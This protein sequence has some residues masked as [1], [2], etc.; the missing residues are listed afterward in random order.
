MVNIT[1]IG[2]FIKPT[3]ERLSKTPVVLY[4]IH[5]FFRI[6]GTHG[7]VAVL[8]LCPVFIDYS[9]SSVLSQISPR[10]LNNLNFCTDIYINVFLTASLALKLTF[11]VNISLE[12]Y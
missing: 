1:I 10:K 5:I 4:N 6:I 11:S 2:K 8:F 12:T 9:N 3:R 7:L